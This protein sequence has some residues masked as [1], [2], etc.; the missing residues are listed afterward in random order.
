MRTVL[1]LDLFRLYYIRWIVAYLPTLQLVAVG[2]H[3]PFVNVCHDRLRWQRHPAVGS[4]LTERSVKVAALKI[5]NGHFRQQRIAVL[6][7]GHEQRCVVFAS[8]H[9]TYLHSAW[10]G[11]RYGRFILLVRYLVYVPCVDNAC[12]GTNA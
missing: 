8:R 4:E 2:H 5:G 6:L 3:K 12:R 7:H 9:R 1:R 11:Y 10:R